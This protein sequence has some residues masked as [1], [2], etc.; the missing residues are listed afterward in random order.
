[1]T[2]VT[3]NERLFRHQL[4]L[5]VPTSTM[6]VFVQATIAQIHC[7][8]FPVYLNVFLPSILVSSLYLAQGA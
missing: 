3:E 1:M 8:L 5:H 2:K 4:L 6:D 7:T